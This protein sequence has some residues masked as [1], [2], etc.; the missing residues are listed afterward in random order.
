[1]KGQQNQPDSADGGRPGDEAPYVK[2]QLGCVMRMFLLVVAVL[3]VGSGCVTMQLQDREMYEEIKRL[4]LPDMGA[5]VSPAAAGIISIF[6]GSGNLYLAIQTGNGGQWFA[7]I[8]NFLLWPFS[9]VWAIPE[10][11]IDGI[12]LR[13]LQVVNYYRNS[14]NGKKQLEQARLKPK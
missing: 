12:T 5:T 3:V 4:G 7:C 13:K 10:T 11:I 14:E 9:P 6:P 1:V 2:G 8:C